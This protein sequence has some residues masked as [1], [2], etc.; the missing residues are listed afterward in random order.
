MPIHTQ[1]PTCGKTAKEASR[2]ER[3][4]HYYVVLQCGHFFKE[5][6]FLLT[7]HNFTSADKS[8]TAFPFQQK[9]TLAVESAGFRA[10]LTYECGL[11]KTITSL[12]TVKN[13]LEVLKPALI[14][15]KTA[16]EVQ[17]I[18][19]VCCILGENYIP[20]PL[21]TG[22]ATPIPGF[23]IHIISFDLCRKLQDKLVNFNLQSA[24]IIDILPEHDKS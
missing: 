2:H 7:D 21:T 10:L 13:N 5:K 12:F 6:K 22:T 1:C 18:K 19:E 11:G 17:W 20:L 16:V 15:V 24:M 14:I 9:D 23:P 8:K 3:S 4:D